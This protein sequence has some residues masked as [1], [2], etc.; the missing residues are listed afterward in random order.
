MGTP[1]NPSAEDGMAHAGEVTTDANDHW[2]FR[3]GCGIQSGRGV[4][5]TV[6]PNN[7][8][9]AVQALADHRALDPGVPEQGE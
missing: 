9:A 3:C 4:E 7:Y 5:P 1:C 6:T 2:Y 8:E